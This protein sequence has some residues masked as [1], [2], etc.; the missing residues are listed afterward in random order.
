MTF[1]LRFPPFLRQEPSSAV[2]TYDSV[3]LT[4]V[5]R[6][7]AGPVRTVKDQW[8]NSRHYV[9]VISN[10]RR[11]WMVLIDGGAE[12][13]VILTGP[14]SGGVAAFCGGTSDWSMNATGLHLAQVLA[15]RYDED[16]FTDVA[17][18]AAIYCDRRTA[19]R[20]LPY[21]TL[22]SHPNLMDFMAP[23]PCPFDTQLAAT[24]RMNPQAFFS[25]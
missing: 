15:L 10:H 4:A 24:S 1:A 19:Q 20:L 6:D 17:R 8:G 23:C 13:N 16:V 5:F 2:A 22:R 11:R 18:V 9:E 14:D 12:G 7:H 3:D 25:F 21:R